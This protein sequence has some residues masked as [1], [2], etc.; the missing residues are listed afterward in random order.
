MIY[1]TGLRAEWVSFVQAVLS[2]MIVYWGY[3][4]I[5]K[6][7]RIIPHNLIAVSIEDGM[8]WLITA[9]YLFVQIYHTSNGSI[10][11]Y[12]VLGIVFGAGLMWRIQRVIEQNA[13]K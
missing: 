6:L 3:F 1:M 5:R 4:C 8:F 12:F 13:K 10:R 2:G 11:W 9:V 7:R